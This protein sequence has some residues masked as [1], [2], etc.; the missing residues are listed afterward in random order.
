VSR[1]ALSGIMLAS[2]FAGVLWGAAVQ[3][4]P[5]RVFVAAQGSD[6]NACTFAAPC[7]TFQHA[8][9]VVAA[10]GEIDVLDPAGYGV[11]TIGKAISIQGHD[12][13]GIAVGIGGTGITIDAGPSDKINLRGLIIEGSGAG[14][15]GIT[16]RVGASLTV[17]SCVVR[18][19]T[20]DGIHFVTDSSSSTSHLS[21]SNTFIGDN[22]EDGILVSW[23]AADT[24][25]TAVFDRVGLYA[26]ANAGIR[27]QDPGSFNGTINATVVDSV[28]AKS[29]YGFRNSSLMPITLMVVRSVAA[30]N[31]TGVSATGSA[32][33]VRVGQSVVT[34]NAVG[35]QALAGAALLSYG[36]NNVDGNTADGAPTGTIAKK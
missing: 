32:A 24:N 13:A 35:L 14:L 20:K 5:A 26:N 28:A 27:V 4:Q 21:V 36:D 10:N 25:I 3:A 11:L 22:G 9:D 6:S 8:H 19:F 30:N 34:G 2:I 1:F 33:T 12:F 18:G 29:L 17:Q 31:G 16:F 7:R 15:H 23:L